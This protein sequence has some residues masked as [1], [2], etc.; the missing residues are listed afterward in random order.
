[1][2]KR[3]FRNLLHKADKN[4]IFFARRGKTNRN[5]ALKQA[6][7]NAR[8]NFEI[9]YKKRSDKPV[10]FYDAYSAEVTGLQV[11]D[12]Y[13]WT[14]QRLY[15]RNED[16]FFNL[17]KKDFRLIIDLDDTRNKPYGEYYSD[18]NSL[19]LKKLKPVKG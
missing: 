18:N 2:V 9:K 4:V 7:S 1:M 3:L 15:E 13:L 16:R 11:I 5:E 12:Y 10:I 14:L 17:L 8:R 19:S 6:L